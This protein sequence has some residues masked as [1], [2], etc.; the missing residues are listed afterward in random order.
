[1]SE[2]KFISKEDY[3]DLVNN[4]EKLKDFINKNNFL[5]ESFYSKQKN[6][7]IIYSNVKT[8]STSLWYSIYLNTNN[9][10]NYNNSY[11]THHWHNDSI[12]FETYKTTL[13]IN[14]FINLM[15]I[16][17]KN[18][19]VADIYRPIFDQCLSVYLNDLH[20]YFQFDINNLNK[21]VKNIQNNIKLIQD[22][23]NEVFISI[24]K[25]LNS[26]YYFEKYDIDYS[27]NS[28]DFDKKYLYYKKNNISYLKL[29]L[30][31]TNKW[32]QILE[33]ILK[34][35]N[36]K[37]LHLNETNQKYNFDLKELFMK[38]YKIPKNIY[39]M[40][41]NNKYF[42]Y[43]YN[44]EEQTIYLQKFK[45]KIQDFSIN[46]ENNIFL[47]F[48]NNNNLINKYSSN[49]EII[50][51]PL[52]FKTTYCDKECFDA[53]C[54]KKKKL[55]NLIDYLDKKTNITSLI[56]DE[57][58]CIKNISE[59][60]KDYN[61][62]DNDIKNKQPIV[63]QNILQ[64]VDPNKNQNINFKQPIIRKTNNLNRLSFY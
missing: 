20:L 47:N 22:R 21:Y 2:D 40:I 14:Q 46:I 34:K 27:V 44:E 57:I 25:H 23:F 35:Q 52:I 55:N 36:I 33:P 9:T 3:Y 4:S 56:K 18:I 7:F 59:F 42:K 37:I 30:C 48:I 5:Y 32:G 12:L 60:R 38:T 6:Y 29:R 51:N 11:R 45:D 10:T 26:D 1:M 50:N 8:G 16:N 39:E 54:I 53:Y 49:I 19:I 31:D 61:D 13:N 63:T 64:I 17:N 62:N 58:K 24:Y 43:Y 41:K 15:N 28:F